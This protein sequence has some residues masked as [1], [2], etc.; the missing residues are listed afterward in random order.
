MLMAPQWK[1]SEAVTRFGHK[2]CQGPTGPAQQDDMR[3]VRT[4]GLGVART[5][6]GSV[7]RHVDE[8]LA[9]LELLEIQP[10]AAVVRGIDRRLGARC[11]RLG[12]LPSSLLASANTVTL[13][14]GRA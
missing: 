7:D 9:E 14:R 10:D 11:L 1:R 8:P 5:D 6:S 13:L 3:F 4:P 2:A 12:H